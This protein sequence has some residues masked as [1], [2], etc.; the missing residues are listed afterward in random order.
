MEESDQ[1]ASGPSS[2]H[3][4]SEIHVD[5]GIKATLESIDTANSRAN[6]NLTTNPSTNA[7]VA[8]AAPLP[9]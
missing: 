6:A 8:S 2:E 7:T 5:E 3:K 9:A 1:S 4:R